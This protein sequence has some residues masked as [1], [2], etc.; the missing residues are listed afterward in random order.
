[1]PPHHLQKPHRLR[2][3]PRPRL[4]PIRHSPRQR[5][6]R[7]ALRLHHRVRGRPGPATS[8]RP[9]DRRGHRRDVAGQEF[10]A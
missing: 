4:A 8:A 10:T 2:Q 5:A 7:R 9:A 3:I 6:K 1:L